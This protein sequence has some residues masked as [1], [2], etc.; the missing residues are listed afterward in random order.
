MFSCCVCLWFMHAII[1]HLRFICVRKNNIQI[2]FHMFLCFNAQIDP[3]EFV[4]GFSEKIT[5]A[6]LLESYTYKVIVALLM[7][8]F[9]V[10]LVVEMTNFWRSNS[11]LGGRSTVK[12]LPT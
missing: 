11:T 3:L 6:Y 4:Q 2:I 5:K 10:N 8:L 9:S 7:L 1:I 12:C